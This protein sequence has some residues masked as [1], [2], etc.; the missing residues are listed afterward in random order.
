MVKDNVFDVSSSSL[1]TVIFAP[2]FTYKHNGSKIERF[3]KKGSEFTIKCESRENPVA[4][5]QW[6]YTDNE[7]DLSTFKLAD[8]IGTSLTRTNMASSMQGIYK[9]VVENKV[10]FAFKHIAVKLQPKSK[11]FSKQNISQK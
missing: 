1:V 7:K 10:G 3:I 9:C 4:T 2:E 6:F 11:Y 8:D 5:V